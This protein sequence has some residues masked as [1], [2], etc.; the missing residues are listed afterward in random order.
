M[1][2]AQWQVWLGGRWTNAT[3]LAAAVYAS[4]CVPVR[5][6]DPVDLNMQPAAWEVRG[7]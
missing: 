2:E 4:G 5:L 6:V 1:T 7:G 3:A